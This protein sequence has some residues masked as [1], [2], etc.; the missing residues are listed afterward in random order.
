[1]QT[2]RFALL[3]GLIVL[4]AL[5]RLIPHPPNFAPIA[6]IALFG[7][8]VF[9]D[10]RLAY[11]VPVVAMLLSDLLLGF[12]DQML[13][14]YAC[15]AAVVWLGSATDTAPVATV[16]TTIAIETRPTETATAPPGQTVFT[17]AVNVYGEGQASGSGAYQPGAMVGVTAVPAAGWRFEGWTGD[18]YMIA[19]ASAPHITMNIVGN[20]S[21]T[22]VFSSNETGGFPALFFVLESAALSVILLVTLL[23]YRRM[24]RGG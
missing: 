6:A 23:V 14:V 5:S 10:R 20:C 4:A 1:M 2:R 12:H 17:L 15:I 16:P 9:A 19:D 22:A 8:A 24:K 7:G 11:A 18:T 13:L 21:L 3:V